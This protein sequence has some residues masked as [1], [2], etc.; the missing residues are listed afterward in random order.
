MRRVPFLVALALILPASAAHG[1][2]NLALNDCGGPSSAV[3]TCVSNSGTAFV[4]VASVTAPPGLTA[5][6]GVEATLDIDF[7]NTPVPSWWMVGAGR[8][9][10]A[11][12][13]AV[14]FSLP[15]SAG[16]CSDYF[17]DAGPV[18]GL[19]SYVI[20]PDPGVGDP[21]GPIGASRVRIRTSSSVTPE[22]AGAAPQ[23]Q[24]GDEIFLFSVTVDRTA[25]IGVGSCPGCVQQGCMM[26][27]RVVL[28]QAPGQG[29]Y[30]LSSPSCLLL[31]GNPYP[32]CYVKAGTTTWGM[33]KTLYR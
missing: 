33:I 6:T 28:T 21:S 31:Q 25:T 17:G 26:L 32:C 23:P 7:N 3:W 8:C 14:G 30:L 20:G 10:P 27:R 12:A 16:S 9:R 19:S 5:L 2:L 13:V 4:A 29:D 15:A 1:Q 11:S 24:A 18:T 22:A